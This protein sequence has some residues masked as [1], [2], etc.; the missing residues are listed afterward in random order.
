MPDIKDNVESINSISEI[1]PELRQESKAPTFALTYGGQYHT[2]IKNC[3]FSKEKALSIEAKYHELYKES[4]T[5]VADK[6]K[7]AS[8]DGYVT[9]A[10]GVRL[11]TPMLKQVIWDSSSMPYEA[12]AEGRTAGNAVSGQS[13]GSLTMR[14]A[15]ELIQRLRLSPFKYDIKICA[16]IHDAVY[17]L[18]RNNIDAVHWLNI[19]LIE[20]MQWQELPEI[21][22]DQVKLGAELDLFYPSWKDKLTLAN[23]LTKEEILKLCKP[24]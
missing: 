11:R 7:Q 15:N 21:Q 1:Y 18:V 2:L 4:D 24:S 20:C 6:L 5:W 10:F 9:L 8:I 14:A 23:K 13:Y 16:I 19:N 22:H 17:F 12:S 3:G